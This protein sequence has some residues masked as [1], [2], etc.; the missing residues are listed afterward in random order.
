MSLGRTRGREDVGR[1]ADG[2]VL[3][4]DCDMRE[5][6]LFR[7][8]LRRRLELLLLRRGLV[9][10]REVDACELRREAGLDDAEAILVAVSCDE[11]KE[12]G[13]VGCCELREELPGSLVTK[14]PGGG[15][16]SL[17]SCPSSGE[18]TNPP[19]GLG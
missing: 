18:G 11:G 15:G 14:R 6:V 12:G 10:L 9:L 2:C 4:L 7:V 13:R 5:A 19:D 1:D 16:L 17:Q 8:E 3:L